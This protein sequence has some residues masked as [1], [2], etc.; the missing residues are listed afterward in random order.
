MDL[1]IMIFY[2]KVFYSLNVQWIRNTI[3]KW[4]C[5]LFNTTERILSV[6]ALSITITK[7]K[8]RKRRSLEKLW[9]CIAKYRKTSY[10]VADH[11]V[12]EVFQYA[13]AKGGQVVGH[14]EHVAHIALLHVG[15]LTLVRWRLTDQRHQVTRWRSPTSQVTISCNFSLNISE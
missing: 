9:R 4:Q 14:L 13:L 5:D 8:Y 7:R 12:Y 15:R 2:T 3:I 11:L 10:V 6:C 1:S